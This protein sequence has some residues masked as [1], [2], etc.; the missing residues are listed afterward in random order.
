MRTSAA[1]SLLLL[2]GAEAF[3]SRPLPVA[4]RESLTVVYQGYVP[5][6]FTA[7]SYKKFKEAEAKKK[8]A[9]LGKLG[10]RG[11]QVGRNRKSAQ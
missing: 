2:A 4:R 6:G 11:F 3:T 10:P 7:E 9:N 5:D 1:V 8:Q